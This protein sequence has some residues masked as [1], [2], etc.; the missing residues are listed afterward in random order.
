MRPTKATAAASA[1]LDVWVPWLAYLGLGVGKD[2]ILGGLVA[3]GVAMVGFL[4]QAYRF[5]GQRS[6]RTWPKVHAVG[7]L[8]TWVGNAVFV[9]GVASDGEMAPVSLCGVGWEEHNLKGI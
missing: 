3:A 8:L 2:F 5:Y 6:L 9:A 4:F 7:V 1:L